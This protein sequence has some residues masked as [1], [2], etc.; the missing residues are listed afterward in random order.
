MVESSHHRHGHVTS[1]PSNVS[2]SKTPDEIPYRAKNTSQCPYRVYVYQAFGQSQITTRMPSKSA[3]DHYLQICRCCN[4]ILG[5]LSFFHSFKIIIIIIIN[6]L[7][8]LIPHTPVLSSYSSPPH[9]HLLLNSSAS[10][11][12][13]VGPGKVSSV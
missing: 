11:S 13:S 1:K 12:G 7:T 6:Y 8:P 5:R 10:Y 4:Q 3:W 2:L 9:F